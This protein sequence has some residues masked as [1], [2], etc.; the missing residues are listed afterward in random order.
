MRMYR[1]LVAA[2][3][4]LLIT[5][6]GCGLKNALTPDDS[7]VEVVN[8]TSVVIETVAASKCGDAEFVVK[9]RD[10]R[11]G[12][13]KCFELKKGCYDLRATFSSRYI[14]AFRFSEDLEKDEVIKWTHED[15]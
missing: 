9:V 4:V 8:R 3:F 1:R 6:S 11:Q 15:S 5:V 2:A 14:D 13:T 12:Q 10:I 7:K